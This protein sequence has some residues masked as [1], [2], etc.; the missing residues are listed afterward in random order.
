MPDR[1]MRT[2]APIVQHT[3][4]EW[5]YGAA[6][7]HAMW[8][9]ALSGYLVGQGMPAMRAILMA[10]RLEAR[11]LV[12]GFE[13]AE[14]QR[15]ERAALEH[16]RLFGF[17]APWEPAFGMAAAPI[18]VWAIQMGASAAGTKTAPV[19]RSQAPE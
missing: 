14:V 13:P 4:A 3:A 18:P 8:Q 6:P 17:R 12:P 19:T 16:G 1:L 9:A 11:G 2:L 10:E 7:V 5:L 15:L